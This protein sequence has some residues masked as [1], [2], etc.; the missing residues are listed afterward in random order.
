MFKEKQMWESSQIIRAICS[1]IGLVE[2]NQMNE[3]RRTRQGE[4]QTNN[5]V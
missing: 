4:K 3:G 5:F 2:T 1:M